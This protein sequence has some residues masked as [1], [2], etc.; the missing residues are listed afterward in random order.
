[1]TGRTNLNQL[2]DSLPPVLSA[3]DTAELLGVTKAGLYNWLRQGVI[4][5]YKVGSNWM[6]LREDLRQVFLD[7]ANTGAQSETDDNE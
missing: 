2:F 3:P 1:M 4:P 7:G 6:I 5:A